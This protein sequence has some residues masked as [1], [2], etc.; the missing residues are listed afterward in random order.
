MVLHTTTNRFDSCILYSMRT[1]AE[2]AERVRGYQRRNLAYVYTFKD[3]PCADCGG[4]FP[5]VCMDFDHVRGTKKFNMAKAVHRSLKAIDE[6]IAKCDVVC[7][8]CHRIRTASRLTL[9]YI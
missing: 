9:K 5:P 6:E 1:K 3:V 7:S 8:N 2:D 4:K